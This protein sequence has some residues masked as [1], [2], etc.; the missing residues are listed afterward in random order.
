MNFGDKAVK[1]SSEIL[2]NLELF[3]NVV[4]IHCLLLGSIAVAAALLFSGIFSDLTLLRT[5]LS[6]SAA[7]LLKAAAA[8]LILI[9]SAALKSTSG[10]VP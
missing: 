3:S 1:N 6:R 8:C 4:I 2:T 10:A 9:P 5:L 7:P